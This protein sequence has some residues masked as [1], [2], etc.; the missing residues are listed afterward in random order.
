[1]TKKVLIASANPWSFCMAVERE[2][3]R[4]HADVTVDALNMFPL[5]SSVSPHWRRRDVVFERINRKYERF[6]APVVNGR[7]ITS[8]IQVNQHDVPEIPSLFADLVKY[9]IG[10]ARIGLA[11]LSSVSSATTIQ[12]PDTLDEFG[13]YLQSSWKSAHLSFQV[14]EAV[15]Q[16]GY[17]RVYIFNGRLCY[18]RPFCDVVGRSAEVI[19]Y[20][21]GSAGNKFIESAVSVHD[22]A[23][24]ADL[25]LAHDVDEAAGESFY[26]ERMGRKPGTEVALLTASQVKDSLPSD[27]AE[28]EVVT[29]FTSCTDELWFVADKPPYGDFGSQFEISLALAE[30]CRSR[31]LKLVI[32]LHP[33]LR[34]KHSSWV[35]EW[36]LEQLAAMGAVVLQ[37]EDSHDSYALVRASKC[38]VTTGSTIGFEASFLGI[39]TAVV[40]TW[41][42]GCLGA[43]VVANS[44]EELADFIANPVLLPQAR[45]RAIAYGSFYKRGGTLLPE[46]DVGSHPG[47]AR[48]AGR[49]VDPVRW[50]AHKVRSLKRRTPANPDALDLRT[51][52]QGGRVLLPPHT[53]YAQAVKKR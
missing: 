48:I 6:V 14:A 26:T 28:G 9:Q 37:P 40:G 30:I 22:P 50:A 5:C 45:S 29:F 33:H 7:D 52:M 27:I 49:I 15:R 23:V 43:S 25:M 36:N 11:V 10:D 41:V 12:I 46:L 17:D 42:G 47:E 20:E 34:F 35:R 32:R 4:R 24:L 13:P 44:R 53:N 16:R 8:D 21:Q 51:G 3:S 31:G 19:R 39:P 2:Y 18:S 38:I 1:M